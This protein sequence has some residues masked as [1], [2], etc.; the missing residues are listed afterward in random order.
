MSRNKPEVVSVNSASRDLARHLEILSKKLQHPTDYEHALHYF[1][2]EFAGDETFLGQGL[3]GT[4]PH[5]MAVIEEVAAKALGSR[6]EVLASRVIH[7]PSH[8]FYH[9]NAALSERVALFFYFE[10]LDTGLLALIPGVRS[11]AQVSRFRLTS[12][13]GVNPE[14]N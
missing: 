9:G 7:V 10:Q 12:G 13:L 11:A 8:G 14:N 3:T 5:L 1:L 6:C 2:E 4:A